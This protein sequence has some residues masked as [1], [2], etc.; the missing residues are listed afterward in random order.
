MAITWPKETARLLTELTGEARPDTAMWIV[1]KDAVE[2]RLEQITLSERAYQSKY[3][4]PFEEYRR[5]WE[6]TDAPADY[7]F[8][9][10]RD[11]LEWEALITRKARLEKMR[12]GFPA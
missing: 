1:L 8:E 7:A 9:S 4:M 11:Y 6:T 3:G 2:H 5:R 12:A 10:E